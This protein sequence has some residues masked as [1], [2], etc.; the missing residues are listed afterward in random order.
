[1]AVRRARTAAHRFKLTVILIAS[2]IGWN[3]FLKIR[4]HNINPIVSP[5]NESGFEN[6]ASRKPLR[7]PPSKMRAQVALTVVRRTDVTVAESQF[8]HGHRSINYNILA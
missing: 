4:L 6:I 3:L 5:S 8:T 2:Q 7:I 1:M